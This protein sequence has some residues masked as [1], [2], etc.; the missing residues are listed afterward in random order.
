MEKLD[1]SSWSRR[2]QYEFFSTCSQPFFSLTFELDVTALYDYVKPRGL[3]FYYA[4]CYTTAA[5]M[6][7]VPEFP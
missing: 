3:S 7:R 1:L 4:L 6:N 5:A 2:R